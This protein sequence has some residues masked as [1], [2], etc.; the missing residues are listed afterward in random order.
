MGAPINEINPGTSL[1]FHKRSLI[2]PDYNPEKSKSE[3]SDVRHTGFYYDSQLTDESMIMSLHPSTYNTGGSWQTFSDGYDPFLGGSIKYSKIPIA[4]CLLSDDPTFSVSNNFTDFNGGNPIEDIF[5]SMKPYAPILGKLSEGLGKTDDKDYGGT[6]NGLIQKGKKFVKD[7][8]GNA[9]TI[10]NKALF[11]QGTRFTYYNG[12]T[13]STGQMEMKFTKFSEYNKKGEFINVA[14]YISEVLAPYCYGRYQSISESGAMDKT[15]DGPLTG[16]MS[17]FIAEYCG[18]Q[19]PPG[20][21]KMDAQNLDKA[22]F[23]TLRLNIG[24]V[25]AVENLLIKSMTFTFSRSQTKH[26]EKPGETVP[27]YADIILSLCP[28]AMVTDNSFKEMLDGNGLKAAMT[29]RA[30]DNKNQLEKMKADRKSAFSEVQIK[31]Y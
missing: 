5:N 21:F 14:K 10:L 4:V 18:V 31:K 19:A 23:G 2:D 28:A 9:E 24:G 30:S 29:T 16:P 12:S 1:E 20:G 6:V 13:F 15:F 7:F 3:L 17:K 25:Y 26:P 8:A 11:I 27:L 22:L